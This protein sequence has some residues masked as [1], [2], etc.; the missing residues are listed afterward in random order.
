MEKRALNKLSHPNI[1]VL[2]TTFQDYGTLYYQMEYLSGGELWSLIKDDSNDQTNQVGCHWSQIPFLF[3]EAINGLEYMHRRGII[4]RDIKPENILLT[5]DGHIKYVDFGTAKDLFQTDLNGPEFVGTP[6]YM[7]PSTVSSKKG[8]GVGPEADLW[9]LGI[10]LYQL[11]LGV[12]AFHAASPY[13]IFLKVK[14]CLLRLPPFLPEGVKDMISLL[15]EKDDDQ[16]FENAAGRVEDKKVPISYDTLRRHRFFAECGQPDFSTVDGIKDVNNRPAVRVPSLKDLCI[17]AV[18]L[19]CI[20]IADKVAANGGYKPEIPWIQQFEI[21]KLL[22]TDQQ[23]VAHFLNCKHKLHL[24]GIYRLFWNSVVDAK[25][26][27]VDSYTRDYIGYNRALQGQWY[28]DFFFAYLSGPEFILDEN[29]TGMEV[30]NL[31][32]AISTINKLRPRFVVASGNFTNTYPNDPNYEIQLINFRKNIARVSES[33]AILHVAGGNDVSSDLPSLLKYRK[34]FGA[35]FY[36][37]WYGGLRCLIINSSLFNENLAS[38]LIKEADAQ[39]IWLDEEIEQ[40]KLCSQHMIIFMHTPWF[41]T[42]IDEEYQDGVNISHKQRVKWLT[43][44]RHSKVKYIFASGL[45]QV[46]K[47]SAFAHEVKDSKNRDIN[48]DN[49]NNE[50][51]TDDIISDGMKPSD[52]IAKAKESGEL[53]S[54]DESDDEN[55]D[56]EEEFLNDD[57]E[58][59]GP[60]IISTS[61]ISN[62][63]EDNSSTSLPGIRI[64]V[65]KEDDITQKFYPLTNLPQV[66]PIPLSV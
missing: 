12:T 21:S 42:H 63:I 19:A 2:H 26:I 27:R 33:I 51:P 35:D 62:K 44:L 6:E 58:Y 1:I 64:V 37:F 13:L 56:G 40:A 10:V 46:S 8:R 23:R 14:R 5:A 24:P 18:G 34:Y 20:E 43:K 38:D 45:N 54:N 16:R 3:A 4:H 32:K 48:N 9:S 57:P 28:K 15:L 39:E 53:Q 29:N 25:C 49:N 65:V 17:R 36:G 7:S 30:E 61:Y 55:N 41:V 59:F 50:E 11:Y 22:V 60:D 52:I 47:L 31:R 66:S